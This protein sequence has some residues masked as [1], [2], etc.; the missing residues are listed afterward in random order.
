M[1]GKQEQRWT[2]YVCPECGKRHGGAYF[3][4]FC[5]CGDR[6]A[7]RVE[8]VPAQHPQA[9]ETGHRVEIL[10]DAGV[11]TAK[12]ICPAEGC[13]EQE[14]YCDARDWFDNVVPEEILTGKATLP[15]V[16]EW[17]VDEEGPEIKLLSEHPLDSEGER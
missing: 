4:H 12:L 13:S 9:G 11:M 15:V 3:C 10:F 14:G 6:R 1:S 7:E 17:P 5:R 16:I 2:I 8:V